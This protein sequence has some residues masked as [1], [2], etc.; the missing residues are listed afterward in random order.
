VYAGDAEFLRDALARL[1]R[2]VGDSHQLD[3]RLGA[4]LGQMVEPGIGPG[5]DEADTYRLV[6]HGGE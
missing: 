4:K 3:P 1:P 5:A 6:G 2:A